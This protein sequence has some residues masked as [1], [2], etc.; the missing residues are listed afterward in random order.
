MVRVKLTH[1]VEGR[2]V[3]IGEMKHYSGNRIRK[4]PSAM[5]NFT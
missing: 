4:S 5:G 3:L 1:T 2:K